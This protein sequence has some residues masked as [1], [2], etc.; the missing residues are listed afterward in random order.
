LNSIATGVISTLLYDIGKYGLAKLFADH[1]GHPVHIAIQRTAEVYR[2]IENLEKTFEIWLQNTE[3][4]RNLAT[5]CAGNQDINIEDLS[6]QLVH[7]SGFYMGDESEAKS[8]EIV[9]QF[10][11]FLNEECLL[12]DT[13]MVYQSQKEDIQHKEI[14]EIVAPI[15]DAI[16]GM[17]REV[18]EIKQSISGL[19]DA[20][21]WKGKYKDSL[22]KNIDHARDLL[23]E[24]RVN[25]AKQLL[26]QQLKVIQSDGDIPRE[27]SFRIYT[28]LGCCEFE[29]DQ[30]IKAA[31]YYELAF[32]LMPENATAITNMAIARKIRGHPEEGLV[33]LEGLLKKEPA[34]ITGL[35]AKANLL[36]ELNR[37]DEAIDVFKRKE[38]NSFNQ[39][40]FKEFKCC[41]TIGYVYYRKK[42]FINSSAFLGKALALDPASPD[43]HLLLG[44]SIAVPILEK[45]MLPWLIPDSQKQALILAENHLNRAYE[46]IQGKESSNKISTVLVN[47]SSLR[48][49]LNNLEG[50]ISDCN[51]AIGIN[52]NISLAHK[53]KGMALSL[54]GHYEDAKNSWLLA[55]EKGESKQEIVPL[56]TH[57]YLTK[58]PAEP[59][60]AIKLI[61]RHFPESEITEKNF[62]VKLELVACYTTTKEHEKARSLL[63]KMTSFAPKKSRLHY[64]YFKYHKSL[65]SYGE[66][67]KSLIAALESADEFDSLLMSLELANYYYERKLYDKAIPFYSKVANHNINNPILLKYLASLYYSSN[68]DINLPVC[69]DICKK[70]RLEFGPSKNITEIEAL[71]Q[72]KLN[73]LADASYLYKELSNIDP[74]N[75]SHKLRLGL[76]EF[77]RGNHSAALEILNDVVGRYEKDAQALVPIAEIFDYMGKKKEALELAYK[78][79]KSSPG[80]PKVHLAYIH[81]FL[82]GD[83]SID[84]EL[85][86]QIIDVGTIVSLSISGSKQLF[87][88]ITPSITERTD[89]LSIDS[90]FG[91]FLKGHKVGDKIKWGKEESTATKVEILEI[92]S[93]YVKAFQ[94][95]LLAFPVHFPAE[96]G[97]K[98]LKV[99]R[100]LKNLLNILD[101][102]AERGT[103]FTDLYRKRR[104]T[105]GAL[106][107]LSGND[108]F[109]T[110]LWLS[111]STDAHLI[112]AS[113]NFQEQQRETLLLE[114][115]NK[116]IIDLIGLFT[117][118]YIDQ[119]ELPN[120]MFPEVYV[121]QASL[122]EITQIIGLCNISKDK[123][124]AI[125]G[126]SGTDYFKKD[127]TPLDVQNKIDFL[128]KIKIFIKDK[129]HVTGIMKPF[130]SSEKRLCEILGTHS[131]ETIRIAIENK[132][133]IYSDDKVFRDLASNE[134]Q[135]GGF[136]IQAILNR[137]L[138]DGR[139]SDEIYYE[140]IIKLILGRYSY[141]SI[142]G[143]V[144]LYSVR[145]AAFNFSSEELS[146]LLEALENRNTSVES[147]AN[148]AANFIK[149]VWLEP[150]KL[151]E[152]SIFLDIVL[153]ALTKEREARIVIETFEICLKKALFILPLHW[154]EI[155]KHLSIMKKNWIYVR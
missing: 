69:L 144:L 140:S 146:G 112:C 13:G 128:N 20:D 119:L 36:A 148:V 122:D 8:V 103:A 143:N 84:N 145:K 91:R 81:L 22:N 130:S 31:E 138:K 154:S 121:S 74:D 152:K 139:I 76:V 39:D 32:I 28:N 45:R 82:S 99:G 109:D 83:N 44:L 114:E 87:T 77:R 155:Q 86:P 71:I 6:R 49:A 18:T 10:F 30:E 72:E 135:I 108:L 94:D 115:P 97:I 67:E 117:L 73:N 101:K 105:I 48:L 52:P 151:R 111:N 136:S 35:C 59:N 7:S 41:Y 17:Q 150:I 89:E 9:R 33:Y 60:E 26:E 11:V 37:L 58:E 19:Q 3:V 64:E 133:A 116:V 15:P 55:L 123:G 4:Q 62:Y 147:A 107:T 131:V 149:Y 57:L 80:D 125:I 54:D 79:L 129:L 43:I 14:L 113:G 5:F 120:N 106:S 127:I 27:I 134:H 1:S 88:I 96:G 47:R 68:K 2:H 21:D 70:F 90:D 46:N 12:S 92:K 137:A 29:L 98:V 42:D 142:S 78:A 56:L 75:Y 63:E 124:F 102:T 16:Y 66:A 132:L 100:N 23:L 141:I 110:W 51:L 65:S 153:R 93:I 104:L 53:N 38:E 34:F 85:N 24:G 95:C 25:T 126:K 40:L 118:N 50:T 61:N